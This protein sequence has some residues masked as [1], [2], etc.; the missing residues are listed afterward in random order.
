MIY[1]AY[2]VNQSRFSIDK[3]IEEVNRDIYPREIFE[4]LEYVNKQL[5]ELDQYFTECKLI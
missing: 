5:D 1:V 2:R 3:T 4:H